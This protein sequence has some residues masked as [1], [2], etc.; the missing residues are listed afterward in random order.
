MDHEVDDR[1]GARAQVTALLI[2]LAFALNVVAMKVVVD[3]TAPLTAVA[4]RMGMVFALCLPWFRP[5]PGRTAALA[6]YG[7]LNG[8]LFL[9]TMNAALAMATNV[10]ALAIAGQLSV[11]FSL[12]LGTLFLGERLGRRQ[13]GGVALAFAG[14]VLLVFDPAIASEV[15]AL[16]VMALAALCWAGGT[17][18]QRRLR[19]VPALTTQAWNG[20]MGMILLA[21][22]AL[23]LEPHAIARIPSMSSSAIGWFAFSVVGATVL[24]Q[25][26]LA[27]LLARHPLSRVMPLMLASPVMAT[28]ASSIYF[29]TAITPVM[30]VGGLISLAGVAIITIGPA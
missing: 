18:V 17:L 13:A 16:L 29:G 1:F 19:G 23:L 15:P 21:P 12:L 6:A 26:A 20:L 28:T 4:L 2:A 30:I 7:A 5:L 9:V 10:G 24:G 11:P 25:G 14:V 3:A 8:G 27:W 22:P